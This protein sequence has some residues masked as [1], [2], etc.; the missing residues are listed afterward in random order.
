[1][2]EIKKT[3]EEYPFL[4][5]TDKESFARFTLETRLPSIIEKVIKSKLYSTEIVKELKQLKNLIPNIKV[6]KVYLEDVEQEYWAYFYNTYLG[7]GLL[8]IPF[9]FAEIY[10]YK[11]LLSITQY[12]HNGIDPFGNIKK[13]EL[14]D[15]LDFI[16]STLENLP[17]LDTENV[18]RLSL[19]GNRADLSQISDTKNLDVQLIAD[20]TSD[21]VE[22]IKNTQVLHLILDNAG[23]ELFSDLALIHHIIKNGLLPKV[24]VYPKKFPLFVSDATLEDITGMLD[25]IEKTS[26]PYFAQDLRCWMKEGKIQIKVDSFWNSPNHFNKLPECIK[27]E[28]GNSD[29]L[30]AKGDANYRRFYEDR[31]IPV[32]FLGG[33]SICKQQFALR[34][35]KS[36]IVAGIDEVKAKKIFEKDSSWMSNG[37]YAIIKKVG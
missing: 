22:S 3:L 30:I 24:V 34:T 9:F 21:L 12:E 23:L 18:I 32:S 33:T 11:H 28:I 6:G 14:A 2:N 5:S 27:S 4:M 15:N 10:F 37:K 25:E 7:K 16:N 35:L 26:Q 19:M 1:M 13:V 36:E 29:V 17:K 20:E 31:D 8:E